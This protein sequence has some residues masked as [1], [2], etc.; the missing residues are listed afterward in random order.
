MRD[1]AQTMREHTQDPL[2]RL[3]DTG[4]SQSRESNGMWRWCEPFARLL[5]DSP[6]GMV[7]AD[8]MGSRTVRLYE[9]LFLYTDPVRKALAGIVIRRTGH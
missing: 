2:A 8:A 9:D 6:I 3:H 5:F 4:Q 1:V 7:A